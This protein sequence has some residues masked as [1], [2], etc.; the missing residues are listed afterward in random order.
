MELRG[1]PLVAGEA[2]GEVVWTDEPLSF[3]GGFDPKTGRVVDRHHGL[4]GRELT[5]T[6]L[7]LPAGRGSSTSSGVLLESVRAGTAPAALITSRLDP[8]LVLG[9]VVATELYGRAPAL[10]QVDEQ[11]FR[12]LRAAGEVTVYADGRIDAPSI[13]P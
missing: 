12:L 4:H 2:R 13:G 3:W 5:G 10:V 1:V 6:V 11:T 8:I 9:L 7:V